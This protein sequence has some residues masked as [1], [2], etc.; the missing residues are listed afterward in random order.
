MDPPEER[1]GVVV[2]GALLLVPQRCHR[3]GAWVEPL[4][5]LLLLLLLLLLLGED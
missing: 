5:G 4:G 3:V 1:L 2:V